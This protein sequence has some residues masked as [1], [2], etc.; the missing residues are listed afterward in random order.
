MSAK[1][2]TLVELIIVISI[3]SL[4]SAIGYVNYSSAQVTARDA[5]R[6]ADL[7]SIYTALELYKQS[8]SLKQYPETSS[9]KYSSAGGDWIGGTPPMVPNFINQMPQDPRQSL[10]DPANLFDPNIFGYA[11]RSIYKT[12]VS[13]PGEPD[14]GENDGGVYFSLAARLESPT[15]PDRNG[16]PGKYSY[17]DGE[18]VVGADIYIINSQ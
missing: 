4:I 11:Y 2:F 8:D 6:K 7:R 5:R 16:S 1:G 14:T 12:G 10:P 17:C 15:D 3:I 13:C 18:V 9:W